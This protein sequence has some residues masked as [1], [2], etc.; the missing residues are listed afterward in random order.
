MLVERMRHASGEGQKR[1]MDVFKANQEVIPRNKEILTESRVGMHGIVLN[2]ALKPIKT[3]PY[4]LTY[5]CEE[6]V[7]KE[8]RKNKKTQGLSRNHGAHGAPMP[9]ASQ[10]NSEECKSW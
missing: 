2:E 8:F 3:Q 1:L 4:R 6:A 7:Q 5:A 9:Y 10:G